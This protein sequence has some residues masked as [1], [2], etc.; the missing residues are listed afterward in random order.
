M[1]VG[2]RVVEKGVT[3][4]GYFGLHVEP[5][6]VAPTDRPTDR[7]LHSPL[8]SDRTTRE[9]RLDFGLTPFIRSKGFLRVSSLG[10]H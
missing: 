4:G 10:C 6:C 3:L 2:V 7:P 8:L 9:L 1:G 5:F